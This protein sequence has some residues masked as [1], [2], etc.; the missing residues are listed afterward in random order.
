MSFGNSRY[1]KNYQYELLRYC[2]SR[3]VIGGAE[4]LFKHFIKTYNPESIISYCDR[5]KFRGDVYKK[6]GFTLK[7]EGKPSCHWYRPKDS[8]HI[9]DGLLRQRGFDQLFG[10]N[11]G[12]GTSNEELMIEH[13]FV[14]IYDCGQDTYVWER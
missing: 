6:L 3:N 9:S 12:K 10:T 8:K 5:S 7:S 11:Y 1:N 14:P 4:K 2:S 13:N